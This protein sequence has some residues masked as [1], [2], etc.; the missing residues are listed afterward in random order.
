MKKKILSIVLSLVIVMSLFSAP[1][2]ASSLETFNHVSFDQVGTAFTVASTGFEPSE[3][4]SY[5]FIAAAYDSEHKLLDVKTKLF[6]MVNTEAAASAIDAKYA[7]NDSGA[8]YYAYG[9]K[10][11]QV[12]SKATTDH[13]AGT[14][15]FAG[16]AYVEE[17]NEVKTMLWEKSDAIRPITASRTFNE[18]SFD[19]TEANVATNAAAFAYGS[20]AGTSPNMAIDG[21]ASTYWMSANNS[22]RKDYFVLDLGQSY[23]ITSLEI[24]LAE[25]SDQDFLILGANLPKYTDRQFLT[26][27]DIIDL[28]PG[29]ATTIVPASKVAFR[30]VIFMQDSSAEKFG[31]AEI[32]VNTDAALAASHTAVGPVVMASLDATTPIVAATDEADRQFSTPASAIASVDM[33]C[34]IDADP[35]TAN[36]Y[37]Y[38]HGL[39]GQYFLLY[40]MQLAKPQKLTHVVW[41]SESANSFDL[42]SS[43]D[44]MIIGSNVLPSGATKYASYASASSPVTYYD[45]FDI[46]A[47]Y[48]GGSYALN[49]TELINGDPHF[50][51]GLQ[52]FEV[53]DAYKDKEYK[54]VGVF[55]VSSSPSARYGN[56]RLRPGTLQAYTQYVPEY[57]VALNAPAFAYGATEGN[58]MYQA[59]DGD[60]GTAWVSANTNA[61]YK[62]YLALDLGAQYSVSSIDVT[63][64]A[65]SGQNFTVYG[66]N[67]AGFIAKTALTGNVSGLTA[68]T[69][70]TI[71]T[72]SSDSFRYIIFEQDAAETAFG[73]SDIKVNSNVQAPERDGV[74][75]RVS[76]D[77]NK[78][79]Y[80]NYPGYAQG[81]GGKA[82][83]PNMTDADPETAYSIG[84][85]GLARAMLMID[86][87]TAQ[88]VSHIVYQ[89]A[90]GDNISGS[91]SYDYIDN[92]LVVASNDEASFNTGVWDVVA[93][94]EK[95]ATY[96]A[97][98]GKYDTGLMVF[99]VASVLGDTPYRYY[100]VVKKDAYAGSHRLTAGTLQVYAQKAPEYNVA[101]H[102]PAFA[103][104]ATEGNDIANAVDGDAST[105]WV[106][107]NTNANY[108]DYLALDL[109]AQYSVTSFDVNMAEGSGQNFTVYGSNDS[110]LASKTQLTDKVSG[111][112]AGTESTIEA[113]STDSF[114][115]IIFEQ[116]AT[117]TA[118]GFNDIK[119]KSTEQAP[120]R[121][122]TTARVAH[123]VNKMWYVNYPGY[124][125][126]NGGTANL[127]NMTDADPATGYTIASGGLDQAML[128]IDLESA[129]KVSHL[130]Y[131]GTAADNINGSSGY[132]HIDNLI[133]IA[134]NDDDA[135][136]AGGEWT[137]LGEIKKPT[138]YVTGD[139]KYDTGLRVFD[140]ASVVGDTAYRYYGVVK[141]EKYAGSHR[142]VVGSLQV[143]APAE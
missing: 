92:V 26:L 55:K 40:M 125:Q 54:Y 85:G 29:T 45:N 56:I 65:D 28:V 49:Q 15:D 64:A 141:T 114:R 74:V 88:T 18:L 97:G 122:A 87:E 118:F 79:W 83:L 12:W 8:G 21:D 93:T 19:L 39:N 10:T 101:L 35:S 98:D 110:G 78:M 143:Y 17:I 100:G 9:D 140:V 38:K 3:D 138:T 59:V 37:D 75:A 136:L 121:T 94:I 51:T 14:L 103:Y 84:S 63:M 81:N 129:K 48:D 82:N 33:T 76:H 34:M 142:M 119:V 91:S 117:E 124:A 95:P 60:A 132:D 80:V 13:L 6:D 90:A 89:G 66:S 41:Q 68:G 23:P 11:K 96:L 36:G 57:N 71:E 67:D 107:A 135:Y 4:R 5:Q 120:E 69:E 43:A 115:Y 7:G 22:N 133:V 77:V 16:E 113:I 105:A 128:M 134:T 42:D 130:V 1:T 111:L 109:G 53:A 126:G 46:L 104:G 30:Y 86:L 127:P 123:N 139:E 58:D 72:I 62:D 99:D 73:F 108:K 52:V 116:D 70:A 61:N 31:F 47:T 137:V 32:K 106:S 20:E 24:T 131:Q 27:D 25:G 2:F 102:A 44:F 50:D 112:T